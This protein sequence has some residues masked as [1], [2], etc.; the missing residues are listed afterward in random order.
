MKEQN[1][2]LLNMKEFSRIQQRFDY[3]EKP[4]NE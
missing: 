4:R 2:P 1:Y 3:N